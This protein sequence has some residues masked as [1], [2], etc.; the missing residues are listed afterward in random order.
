MRNS[1]SQ[2]DT[3][4]NVCNDA[5]YTQTFELVMYVKTALNSISSDPTVAVIKAVNDIVSF[6]DNLLSDFNSRVRN[7]KDIYDDV[8]YYFND[9]EL[10]SKFEVYESE[11]KDV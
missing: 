5:N 4:I 1:L 10:T 11:M 7:S 9:A 2:F 8:D 6:T 3:S